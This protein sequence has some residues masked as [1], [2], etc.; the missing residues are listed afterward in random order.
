LAENTNERFNTKANISWI[1]R[2]LLQQNKETNPEKDAMF[3]KKPLS[4]LCASCDQDLKGNNN[5]MGQSH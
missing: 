4:D 1:K 3:S 2:V 5:K